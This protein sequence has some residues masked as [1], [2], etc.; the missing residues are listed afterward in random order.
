[1]PLTQATNYLNEHLYVFNPNASLQHHA[2]FHWENGQIWG[3]LSNLKL[4]GY[5][6]V[7]ELLFP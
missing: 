6:K 7:N 2:A 1:M 3:K 5:A 4:S